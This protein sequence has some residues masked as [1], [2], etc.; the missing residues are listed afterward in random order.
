VRQ[1][2]DIKRGFESGASVRADHEFTDA[3]RLGAIAVVSAVL[4]A[5]LVIGLGQSLL[6]QAEARADERPVLVAAALR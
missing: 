6:P 5:T 1:V 2:L 4:T 3:V